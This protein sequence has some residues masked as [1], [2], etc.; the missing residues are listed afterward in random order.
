MCV[1]VCVRIGGVYTCACE[2]GRCICEDGSVFTCAC[3]LTL[4]A[5]SSPPKTFSSVTDCLAYFSSHGLVELPNTNI[6]EDS[7]QL[8]RVTPIN[9]IVSYTT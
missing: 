2:D 3:V 9:P 5:F 1:C 7:Y 8:P 6:D 4:I